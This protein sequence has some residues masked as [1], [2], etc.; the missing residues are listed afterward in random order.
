MTR[1]MPTREDR[2]RARRPAPRSEIQFGVNPQVAAH[3]EECRR[4]MWK[5]IGITAMLM[6]ALVALSVFAVVVAAIAEHV[7]GGVPR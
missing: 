3:R 2:E 4:R 5:A 7:T 6:S 1:G